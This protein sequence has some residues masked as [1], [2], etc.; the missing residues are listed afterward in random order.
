MFRSLLTSSPLYLTRTL[1]TRASLLSALSWLV[2]VRTQA[3]QIADIISAQAFLYS[4]YIVLNA[5]FSSVLGAVIDKD[6]KATGNI[7][8][9]L[10]HVGGYA[11]PFHPFPSLI[12]LSLSVFN[13]R[14][15]AELSS[16]PLSSQ[17]A[18]SPSTRRL[19]VA[20]APMVMPAVREKM[21]SPS[22]K[23]R[24]ASLQT[25]TLLKS[26]AHNRIPLIIIHVP[27]TI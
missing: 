20:L 27:P 24:T 18:R 13:S 19:S 11:N 22:S 16:L 23:R 2:V 9:S 1:A 7:Q 26:S 8:N 17:L 21:P 12:M 3:P 25:R 4:T 15:V 14:S 6:F 10:A 5:V